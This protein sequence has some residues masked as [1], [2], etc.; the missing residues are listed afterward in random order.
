MA[1]HKQRKKYKPAARGRKL[2]RHKHF[3]ESI[4]ART[5]IG[6]LSFFLCLRGI[7]R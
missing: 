5:R 6:N 3:R 1:V 2:V 7:L 4:K